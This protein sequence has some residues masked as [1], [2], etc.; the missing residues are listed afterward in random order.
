MD[1]EVLQKATFAGGCFWC[2]EPPFKDLTGVESVTSGYI[3]GHLKNPTYEQVCT[4][5]TGHTEAV[6]IVFDPSKISYQQLLEIF[7]RNIDPTTENRQFVDEGT[8]YRTGIF[9]HSDEQRRLAEES[10]NQL[11]EE[12]RFEA[13]I[14]SE[15]T[16]ASEF[17]PAENYHQ[18]Y[19]RLRP[20]QYQMYRAGSGRD[21]YLK[22]VW[23][24]EHTGH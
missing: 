21:E 16:Q 5:R 13:P 1:K 12:G 9:Y 10:R 7:W 14:V 8:Q 22:E 18:G 17:Y 11:E 20:M 15:I 2:M 23:G 3:G 6:Q 24:D 4:G 19:C